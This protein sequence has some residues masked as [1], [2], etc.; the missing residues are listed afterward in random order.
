MTN[1][2]F[3]LG[4]LPQSLRDSSLREGAIKASLFEGGGAAAGGDG[5]SAQGSTTSKQKCH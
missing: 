2:D 4:L 5:G 3:L 1:F